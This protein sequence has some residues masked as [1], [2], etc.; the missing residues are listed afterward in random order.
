[1]VFI[2]YLV[3]KQIMSLMTYKIYFTDDL[4]DSSDGGVHIIKKDQV[5]GK[6]FYDQTHPND[7]KIMKGDDLTNRKN[8]KA[9]T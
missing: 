3:T 6:L 5:I 1:L 2:E 4:L 9:Y 7:V 8:K